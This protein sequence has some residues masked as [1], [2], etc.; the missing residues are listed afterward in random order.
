MVTSIFATEFTNDPIEDK[1]RSGHCFPLL[2]LCFLLSLYAVLGLAA[3]VITA[4]FAAMLFQ[5][6]FFSTYQ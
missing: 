1:G 3:T 4:S 5:Q 2:L 6:L